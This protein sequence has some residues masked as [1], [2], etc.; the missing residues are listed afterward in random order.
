MCRI[1]AVGTGRHLFDIFGGA[2][3]QDRH[4]ALEISLET[5][6]RDFCVTAGHS[7]VFLPETRQEGLK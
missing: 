4:Q 2:A 3:R 1:A 6:L 7:T 5:L